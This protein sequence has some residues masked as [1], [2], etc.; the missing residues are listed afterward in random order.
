MNNAQIADTFED[1]S[2]GYSAGLILTYHELGDAERM[3][4]LVGRL[5]AS[6]VGPA[7]LAIDLAITGGVLR[8]DLDDAPNLKKRLEEAQIDPAA[9]K[10]STAP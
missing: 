5:D 4:S 7:L 6:K 1:R 9:F 8:F 3:R 10:T 2:I